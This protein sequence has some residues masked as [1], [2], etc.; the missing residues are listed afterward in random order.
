MSKLIEQFEYE[1][2]SALMVEFFG[3]YIHHVYQLLKEVR[4]E[5]DSNGKAAN[6]GKLVGCTSFSKVGFAQRNRIPNDNAK[7]EDTMWSMYKCFEFILTNNIANEDL[8]ILFIEK[9]NNLRE[10]EVKYYLTE[11]KGE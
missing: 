10:F 2:I 8:K 11:G 4:R 3:I 5:I 6:F 1:S 7:L 9:I